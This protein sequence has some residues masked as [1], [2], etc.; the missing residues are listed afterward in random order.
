M[1]HD[2]KATALHVFYLDLLGR[3][4]DMEWLFDL[5]A[6]FAGYPRVDAGALV[7]TFS[8]EEVRTAMEGMNRAS[9]P[10]PDRLG[11]NFYWAA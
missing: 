6:L 11:P 3:A 1:S 5:E 2:A 7:A 8:L 9:A 10:G 4:M